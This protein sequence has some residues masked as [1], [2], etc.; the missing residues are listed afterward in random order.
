MYTDD[1]WTTLL[2][3]KGDDVISTTTTNRQAWWPRQDQWTVPRRCRIIRLSWT[4]LNGLGLT[5]PASGQIL[6]AIHWFVNT[7]SV[8]FIMPSGHIKAVYL[9]TVGWGVRRFHAPH[10]KG[11]D[12]VQT[13]L[14]VCCY[15]ITGLLTQNFYNW[16]RSAKWILNVYTSGGKSQKWKMEL[17]FKKN[18]V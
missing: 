6:F 12:K 10:T 18:I 14:S 9:K 8:I 13:G 4:V 15:K 2:N 3:Y 7:F 16:L 17:V 5:E 11:H 1:R